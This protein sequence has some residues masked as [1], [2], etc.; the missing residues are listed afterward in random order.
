M[1]ASPI[2]LAPNGFPWRAAV[3]GVAVIVGGIVGGTILFPNA[4][5]GGVFIVTALVGIAAFA[6]SLG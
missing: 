4:A 3:V 5:I 6:G 1:K 2:I